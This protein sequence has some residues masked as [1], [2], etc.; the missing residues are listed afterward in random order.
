ML[1]VRYKC[2]VKDEILRF[3]VFKD[4]SVMGHIE[5][6]MRSGSPITLDEIRTINLEQVL[7]SAPR[8]LTPWLIRP[9]EE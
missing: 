1:Q 6:A 4:D 9:R 5:L 7:T 3:D 2:V 8:H